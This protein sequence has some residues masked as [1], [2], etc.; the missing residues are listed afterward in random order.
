MKNLRK[1]LSILLVMTIITGLFA[2]APFS[3]GA[4][5]HLVISWGAIQNVIEGITTGTVLLTRGITA[6][7]DDDGI[8][9]ELYW[10]AAKAYFA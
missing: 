7:G 6:E 8:T 10:Q 1:A 4:S 3:V 5:E 9:I 2:A